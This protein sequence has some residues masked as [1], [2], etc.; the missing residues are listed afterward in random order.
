MI[1]FAKALRLVL[2]HCARRPATKIPAAQAPGFVL[3]EPLVARSP[4]PRFDAS[5]VDGYAVYAADIADSSIKL[6]VMLPLQDTI[7]AGDARKLELKRGQAVRILTGALVP[8]G[9]DAVVMQEHVRTKSGKVVFV[10]PTPAGANIRFS[11]DEYQR[12]ERILDAGTI[13]TPPVAAMLATM[14]RRTVRVFRKPRVAVVVTGDELRTPG[15]KLARGHMYDSNSPGL[16]S[17]LRAMGVDNIRAYRVG[18]DRA[19]T[20][21]V[22]RRALSGADVVISSGG[23]S[24]GSSDYVKDI[25]GRLNVRSIFW[26]VAIKPGKP[27][28]FGKRRNILVFGL[29]G[30]P[31]AALLGFQLFIKPALL[32]MMGATNIGLPILNALLTAPI[33]KKSGR[34]EFVRGIL[35]NNND[36]ELQV[37]PARGQDSHMMGGLAT[38]HCLIWFPREAVS[39][40]TGSKVYISLLQWGTQ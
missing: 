12:G 25:L 37:Q 14:G 30:N 9:A 2:K 18:D 13:V 39:L 27:I 40:G 29:P 34:M 15:S 7:R 21:Q 10:K 1:D 3:A 6:P 38:A 19:G 11:G 31:V 33:K 22:F 35:T 32:R 17:A 20:E 4:L 16:V 26:K 36:G 5:A 23:V 24:V 8:A 28:Y